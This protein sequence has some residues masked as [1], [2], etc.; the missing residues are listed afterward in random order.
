MSSTFS[1]LSILCEHEYLEII[2]YVQFS[3]LEL[4]VFLFC[5]SC[6]SLLQLISVILFYKMRLVLKC[7]SFDFAV[8]CLGETFET[9]IRCQRKL[10]SK[11]FL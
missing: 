1:Y 11:T 6:A 8:A 2:T 9:Y 4:C 5:V 10:D 3:V 7:F